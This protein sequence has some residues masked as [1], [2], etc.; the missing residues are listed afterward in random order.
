MDAGE[1]DIL[2]IKINLVNM[3]DVFTN[4]QIYL[5]SSIRNYCKKKK[6]IRN[7]CFCRQIINIKL[8][9]GNYF[10]AN[11]LSIYSFKFTL[12]VVLIN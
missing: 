1:E 11:A 9:K 4:L 12:A 7:I 3:V 8:L 6:D 10:L 2:A 5:I